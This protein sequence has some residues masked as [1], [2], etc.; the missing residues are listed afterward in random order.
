MLIL[1][2]FIINGDTKDPMFFYLHD[3]FAINFQFETKRR[4]LFWA[5][6]SD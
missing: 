6:A 4:K 3:D 5:R 1:V 2:K